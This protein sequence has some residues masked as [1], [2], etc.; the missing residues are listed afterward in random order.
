MKGTPKNK[1]VLFDIGI[2]GPLAGLIVTIPILLYGLSLSKLGTIESSP[3]G[4]LEGNSILY[5]LAKYIVFGQM[6]PA[7]VEPQGFL[8][9]VKY[10]FTGS[11]V[12]FG[13]TDVFIH[14]VAT[15]GWGGLLVTGLNL[16]P[17]GTL[18]GGH[19]VYAL[20]GER[21]KK[22]FPFIISI[23]AIL[24]LSWNGWWLW[25]A[26]LFL[27]GRNNAQLLDQITPLDPKRRVLA[28]IMLILFFL[29]F[30]PVPFITL[31]S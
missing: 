4:F 2:A 14:Q 6:L 19:V 8:Y 30:M 13:G 27:L 26:L 28:V 5:L 12:P 25:A 16:I 20:F 15:A 1:R 9:W 7:P 10:L 29:I 18:D 11:P 24:G 17:A 31:A 23:L 21:T 3:T 22:A